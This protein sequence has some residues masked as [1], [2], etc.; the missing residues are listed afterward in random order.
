MHQK[1]IYKI[2]DGKSVELFCGTKY[3]TDFQV[4]RIMDEWIYLVPK[5]P[6]IVTCYEVF[7]DNFLY[8]QVCEYCEGYENVYTKIKES[9]FGDI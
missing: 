1:Y 8:L 7:K 4:N 9:N 5:T 3:P 2:I 6:H